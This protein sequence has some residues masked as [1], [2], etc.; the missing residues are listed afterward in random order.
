VDDSVIEVGAASYIRYEITKLQEGLRRLGEPDFVELLASVAEE[1]VVVLRNGGTVFFCG[2]GGSAADAQHLAA[3]LIGKQNYDRPPASGI[4][5]TVD[6]SAVT[7]LGNDYGYES[8]FARQLA[9][10]GRPGDAL[11]GL[12][13][14]GN[15]ANVVAAVEEAKR[16]GIRSIA[17]TGSSPR[18]LGIADRVLAVPA[19]ET[20]KIQELHITCG[21]IIFALVERSLFPQMTDVTLP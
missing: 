11:L 18:R 3:E 1:V 15:S 19:Q 17:F 2:N 4:A 8:V 16:R 13:T 5:L 21:H 7:A 12:S 14:S 10:L 6:S 20:A 9:G